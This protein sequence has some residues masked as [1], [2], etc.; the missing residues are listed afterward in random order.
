M[1]SAGL[2]L[3]Y[4]SIV[5]FAVFL[6]IGVIQFTIRAKAGNPGRETACMANLKAIEGAKGYWALLMKKQPTD[7]PTDA[8]IFGPDKAIREKPQCPAGGIYTL[9]AVSNLPSCSVHGALSR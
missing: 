2:G 9:N 1:A 8:D 5:L 7:V 6:T 4:F 3:G